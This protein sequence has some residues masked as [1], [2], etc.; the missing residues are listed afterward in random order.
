MKSTER[1]WPWTVLYTTETF[2]R[3][4]LTMRNKHLW[5]ERADE[6]PINAMSSQQWN[7]ALLVSHFVVDTE[8]F[9]QF[10]NHSCMYLVG[11]RIKLGG[12]RT[13]T[14]WN[15][16]KHTKFLILDVAW[17]YACFMSCC[18]LQVGA[19]VTGRSALTSYIANRKICNLPVCIVSFISAR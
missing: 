9:G 6:Q 3:K 10:R 1:A 13:V 15:Q 12:A 5:N 7:T 16:L 2:V 14:W 17:F 18:V 8:P 11:P 19:K 4:T